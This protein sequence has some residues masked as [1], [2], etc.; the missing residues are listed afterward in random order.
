MGNRPAKGGVA[1]EVRV[2]RGARRRRY[3]VGTWDRPGRLDFP[4]SA[5]RVSHSLNSGLCPDLPPSSRF[6]A[7]PA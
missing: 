3:A 2:W 6:F 7:L 5:C 1:R 4:L